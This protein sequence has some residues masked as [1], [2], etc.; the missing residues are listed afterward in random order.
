M[1]LT[2][3]RLP[4]VVERS[5]ARLPSAERGSSPQ[6]TNA[7]DF[8]VVYNFLVRQAPLN[9]HLIAAIQEDLVTCLVAGS[10]QPFGFNSP[11]STWHADPACY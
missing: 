5:Q 11:I 7:V 2:Q 4:T 6:A 3:T 10:E 1:Q 9:Q 8:S